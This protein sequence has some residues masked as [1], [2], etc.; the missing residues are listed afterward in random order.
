MVIELF[1]RLTRWSQHPLWILGRVL[2]TVRLSERMQ[3]FRDALQAGELITG[4]AAAGMYRIKG[5]R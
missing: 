5:R 1:L 3:M 4:A 2:T